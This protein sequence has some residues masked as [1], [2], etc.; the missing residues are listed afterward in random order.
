MS[1]QKVLLHIYYYDEP[2]KEELNF[3]IFVEISSSLWIFFYLR[4]LIMFSVSS[5]VDGL[6]LT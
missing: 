3:S 1:V 6:L 4:T 5:V 2:I